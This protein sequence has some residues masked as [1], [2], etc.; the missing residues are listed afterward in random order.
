MI[1][2]FYPIICNNMEFYIKTKLISLFLIMLLMV[3]FSNPLKAEVDP[4]TKALL[5]MAA[6]GTVGGALLGLASQLAFDTG[7]RSVPQG[8][9]LGLYAGLLFGGYIVGSYAIKKSKWGGQREIYDNL[10]P[11]ESG[12]VKG[13]GYYQRWE[14]YLEDSRYKNS[15]KIKANR[16]DNVP[17]LYLEFIRY[18]F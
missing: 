13:G 2:L 7:G 18:Q 9:S 11:Y 4:K 16:P 10:S 14:P 12:G 1:K 17:D 15:L 6:Y 5:S 3:S 8:A